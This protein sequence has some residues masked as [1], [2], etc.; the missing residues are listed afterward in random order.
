[1]SKEKELIAFIRGAMLADRRLVEQGMKKND[2]KNIEFRGCLYVID[3]ALTEYYKVRSTRTVSK[4]LFPSDEKGFELDGLSNNTI[5]E[6]S[7][8]WG[9]HK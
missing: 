5:K 4:P 9:R 3:K 8:R 6:N 7:I 1:M 2:I